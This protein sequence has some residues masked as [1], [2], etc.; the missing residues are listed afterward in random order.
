MTTIHY[1]KLFIIEA[2]EQL[3]LVNSFLIGLEQHPEQ[4]EILY[5]I[6]RSMHSLKAMAASMD[7]TTLAKLLHKLEDCLD[8][9]ITQNTPLSMEI[10]DCLFNCL[11]MLEMLLEEVRSGNNLHLNVESVVLALERVMPAKVTTFAF[12]AEL[13]L[14]ELEKQNLIAVCGQQ[15]TDVF[16]IDIYLSRDCQ[17]KAARVFMVFDKLSNFGEIVKSCPDIESLEMNLFGEMFSVLFLTS[18]TEQYVLAELEKMLELEKI[19]IKH[20]DN[21]SAFPGE[22]PMVKK[23]NSVENGNDFVQQMARKKIQSVRVSAKKLDRLMDLMSRLTIAKDRLMTDALC[24]HIEPLNAALKHID[25]LIAEMQVEV[26]RIRIIPLSQIFGS[27]ARLVKN[28]ARKQGKQV[29][30]SINCMDIELDRI[31][32]DEI[33]APLVH[34]LCNSID[35]GIETSLQRKDL[36]KHIPG[37]ILLK[38]VKKG[39]S[40]VIEVSDDGRGMDVELLRQIAVEKKI[41]D[42][43]DALNLSEDAVLQLI[44]LPG[45][46]S[47][48]EVTSTCGRGIGMDVVKAKIERLGGKLSFSSV[49]GHGSIFKLE[50]P[51]ALIKIE[52]QPFEIHN[53]VYAV[54]VEYLSE[55]R[56]ISKEQVQEDTQIVNIG[57][58]KIPLLCLTEEKIALKDNLNLL[59]IKYNHKKC[60]LLADKVLEKQKAIVKSVDNDCGKFKKFTE[61]ACLVDGRKALIVSI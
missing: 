49:A 52:L 8:G 10:I 34:I 2:E 47:V 54:C 1:K 55:I 15:Q 36:G 13:C 39:M 17:L 6:F 46:S 7:I 4:R 9:L 19:E 33:T 53:S 3:Q 43:K 23:D 32:L 60:G 48:K 37:N 50:I 59:I 25:N 38:A 57:E 35:H 21:L 41:L 20:I 11:D 5:K 40:V 31:I 29:K 61:Q 26:T 44:T 45:F 51:V 42:D 56:P 58:E 30:L 24:C 27:F 28:L 16:R 14:S 22:I 18:F 12:Q